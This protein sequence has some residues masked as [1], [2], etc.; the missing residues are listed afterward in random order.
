[1]LESADKSAGREDM[2][3][4]SRWPSGHSFCQGSRLSSMQD[5]VLK[6]SVGKLHWLG[7]KEEGC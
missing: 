3:T 4:C 5:I 7:A 1:M 6:V 2:F